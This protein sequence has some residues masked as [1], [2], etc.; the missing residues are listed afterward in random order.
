MSRYVIGTVIYENFDALCNAMEGLFGKGSVE[1]SADGSNKLSAHGYGNDNRDH[2]I[3]KV[4]AVVR[5]QAIGS[6]SNDLPIRRETDGTYRLVI[7]EYDAGEGAYAGHE[8]AVCRRL[9]WDVKGAK[10]IQGKLAQE[11][12]MHVIKKML[13]K[14]KTYTL[15]SET[16][17]KD[18]VHIRVRI[19]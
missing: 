10:A 15:D 1:R 2:E 6:S 3:G 19:T 5:R 18:G 11:Y 4:A 17:Q 16:R 14:N 12:G 8:P 9:G 13:P 7:S